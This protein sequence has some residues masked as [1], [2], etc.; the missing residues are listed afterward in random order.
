[1]VRESFA[2]CVQRHS[3]A[4]EVLLLDLVT[5]TDPKKR[6]KLAQL[7]MRSL[8][9]IEIMADQRIDRSAK[10]AQRRDGKNLAE[11]AAAAVGFRG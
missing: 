1:M 7:G 5:E 10:E 11:T 6:G 8:A 9:E 2:A 3:A 4:L